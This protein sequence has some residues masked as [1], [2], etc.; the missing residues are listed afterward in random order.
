[1]PAQRA[2]EVVE[3]R[4]VVDAEALLKRLEWQVIR[5]LDGLLQG[6]YRSLF[7]G[8]GF[9]LAEV[10]EYQPEDD[11]RYMDWN[12]TA[13]M[14]HAYVRQYIEDRDINAWLLLDLSGSVDFGT[15]RSRKRDLVVD[16]AAVITRLLTRHGNKV[17][18]MT[19]SAGVDDLLAPRGGYRHTLHLL[20]S[21][22]RPG[23]QRQR[24]ATDLAAVLDRAARTLRRRSLVF[25]VSDFITRPG[26]EAPLARLARRHEVLAVWLR[27]PREEELPPIGPLVLEDAE[28]GEQ[29]YVDTQDRGFQVRF[30][31][32]VQERKQRLQR[33]FARHGIDVL[34]LSTDRDLV[35]DMS[36]FVLLR[37][38]LRRRQ[39]NAP[40]RAF[41][42]AAAAN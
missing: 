12:V 3:P 19:F 1:M 24:G 22:T 18:A 15:A 6:D 13:R 33:L 37:R 27:D 26:W 35:D 34:S 39:V 21:L 4:S 9:D 30:H 28:T 2:I 36:R 14:D 41:S 7:T 10:R 20:H 8:H 16:F 17:G 5:R 25:I 32:L 40:A 31:S 42:R 23:R 38:E 29:V 11:V